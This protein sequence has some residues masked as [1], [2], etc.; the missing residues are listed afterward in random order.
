MGEGGSRTHTHSKCCSHPN[1][2][3][4]HDIG[5]GGVSSGGDGCWLLVE[6]EGEGGGF[7]VHSGGGGGVVIVIVGGGEAA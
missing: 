5:V 7:V 2:D 6:V 3:Q 1:L 4:P